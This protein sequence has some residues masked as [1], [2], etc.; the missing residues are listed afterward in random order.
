[1]TRL[2]RTDTP[3]GLA[4]EDTALGGGVPCPVAAAMADSWLRMAA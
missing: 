3:H 2:R 4:L 1:M